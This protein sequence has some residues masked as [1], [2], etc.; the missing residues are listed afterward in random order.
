MC[1]PD[2]DAPGLDERVKLPLGR[3]PVAACLA[4]LAAAPVVASRAEAKFE[5]PIAFS[6]KIHVQDNGIACLHCH[7][8]ARR[9]PV[10]G[11]P[12][13]QRCAGCHTTIAKDKPEVLKTMGYWERNEPIPWQRVHDLPDYVRFNHKRHVLAQVE[14]RECHGAVET[15]EAAQQVSSLTMGFCLQCHRKRNASTDCLTCHY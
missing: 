14:C 12:S 8:Y 3:Q 1:R 10:A 13:V 7:A 4:L 11:L 5:Q 2:Y 15:M 9:G 6:H